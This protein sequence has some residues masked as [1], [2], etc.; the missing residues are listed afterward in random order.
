MF[1]VLLA[2]AACRSS[3]P[4]AEAGVASADASD[5][6]AS[7][8]AADATDAADAA[9]PS[10]SASVG[11]AP[12][13]APPRPLPSVDH[14]LAPFRGTGAH[15]FVAMA[16]TDRSAP[17]DARR[18]FASLAPGD[19]P[20]RARPVLVASFTKLFTAV[21]TL[22]MVERGELSL[23]DTIA[24]R[25]PAL[26][27]RPWA[28]STIRELLTHTSLVPELD[29][30]RGYYRRA[31]VDFT[32]PVTVLAANVPRDWVE[33]RGVYKYRNAEVALVGAILAARS[34]LPAERVLQR[35]VF[36]VAGMKHAGLLVD[37][38][39]APPG[40]DLA[41]MGAIRP[42][43]FFTAGAGYASAEDL[44]A[45]FDALAGSELLTEASKALLFDGAKERG[46]GALSCWVYPFAGAD[47][48]TTTLVERPGSFG[49]VRLFT[50]FFP[51]E[52]RAVVAWTGDG[53]EISRP[54]SKKG[55]G[56]ALARAALD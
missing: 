19:T 25:L 52:R 46:D 6:A 30:K 40:L 26:A 8:D 16:S 42:Q 49:N 34:E 13:S 14:L 3:E 5:A 50:A 33:K 37:P 28:P 48:G 32:A 20:D 22:R 9:P 2:S 41:P 27:A 39:G 24:Q 47:G 11:A 56:P 4:R 18:I 44:L 12:P 51:G 31:D 7:A 54:R 23:D 55:I 1:V 38:H 53:V 45:F 43:N 29:E 21:A 35:E 36:D 17:A 15:G 10:A